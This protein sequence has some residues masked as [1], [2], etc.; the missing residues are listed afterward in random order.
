MCFTLYLKEDVK[1]DGSLKEGVEMYKG[2]PPGGYRNKAIEE[3]ADY[4]DDD[5]EESDDEEEAEKPA[6]AA[7]S[8]GEGKGNA[9]TSADDV[10]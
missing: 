5:E 10:D 2:K 1:E 3:N 9:A 4:D 7:K 8:A 6:A